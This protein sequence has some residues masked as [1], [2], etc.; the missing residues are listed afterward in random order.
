MLVNK[1]GNNMTDIILSFIRR[2]EPGYRLFKDIKYLINDKP[3]HYN[4]N[5]HPLEVII[6]LIVELNIPLRCDIEKVNMAE[7]INFF[8]EIKTEDS[9]KEI[10]LAR[11]LTQIRKLKCMN[12]YIRKP[13]YFLELFNKFNENLLN[14]G[15][16]YIYEKETH[17]LSC[18]Q[19]LHVIS[20]D[21]TSR[22]HLNIYHLDGQHNLISFNKNICSKCKNPKISN[23]M[24]TLEFYVKYWLCTGIQ[25]LH[26]KIILNKTNKIYELKA[27]ITYTDS[28]P[29]G[30]YDVIIKRSDGWYFFNKSYIK[31]MTFQEIIEIKSSIH[32]RFYKLVE[33]N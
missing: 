16:K 19:E 29:V 26:E 9:D 12:L 8:N 10:S 2:P 28:E 14:L 1:I 4:I 11:F 6:R 13:S 32:Y 15:N 17:C 25:S 33:S 31:K 23:K 27:V 7:I 5:G 18:N 24:S 22:C 3:Y 21:D 30:G 20:R